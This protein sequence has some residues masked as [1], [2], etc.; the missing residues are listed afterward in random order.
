M[1]LEKT[2]YEWMTELSISVSKKYVTERLV[3]HPEY[4]SIVCVTDTLDDLHI[5]N[6]ALR[7]NC[8]LI[9][10]ISNPSLVFTPNGDVFNKNEGTFVLVDDLTELK[11]DG[12]NVDHLLNSIAILAEPSTLVVNSEN[13][14]NL[15]EERRGKQRQF[16]LAS[17]VVLMSLTFL[18]WRQA[19]LLSIV[20]YFT[21]FLGFGFSCLIV[22]LKE[23]NIDISAFHRLCHLRKNVNCEVVLHS[24]ASRILHSIGWSDAGIVYFSSLLLF[25]DIILLGPIGDHSKITAILLSTSACI[26]YT[27]YSIYLQ[28]F[29]LKHWCPI[30]LAIVAI[31]WTQFLSLMEDFRFKEMVSISSSAIWL[32]LILA[33][34][35]LV[36][37]LYL[38]KPLIQHIQNRKGKSVTLARFTRRP[39]VFMAVLERQQCV[40]IAPFEYDFQLGNAFSPVQVIV[41]CDPI[42]LPCA[43]E[44]LGWDTIIS[45]YQEDIGI[46][47]RFFIG[48]GGESANRI[49]IVTYIFQC[50]IELAQR[51]NEKERMA[52]G[53]KMLNDWFS[54]LNFETFK[55]LYSSDNSANT[56]NIIF[57]QSFW[58]REND[59]NTTPSVFINERK[60]PSI[61]NSQD[62][63]LFL[64]EFVK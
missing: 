25:Q 20:L 35:N 28:W 38:V 63:N 11:S 8:E 48:E 13:E 3:T 2:F 22:L 59:I 31:I 1:L 51:V 23:T 42:C 4:P 26:P 41:V 21:T 34:I 47:F 52:I 49:K 62:L 56:S 57:Q 36:L 44:H 50:W 45:N 55:S 16:F 19:N 46:T 32:L 39:D 6:I 53:R 7:L 14:K 5:P 58:L 24:P 37:W 61:Y 15:L 27:F 12:K 9:E 43:M 64:R 33:V 30:C 40:N 29:K 54:F 17:V 60:V 18:L 10:K